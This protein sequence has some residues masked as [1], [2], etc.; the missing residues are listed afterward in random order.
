MH[1][2]L[3]LI[4]ILFLKYCFISSLHQVLA[5]AWGIFDLPCR[6]FTCSM[7]SL[8]RGVYP[9]RDWTQAP[10]LGARILIPGPLGE[11]PTWPILLKTIDVRAHRKHMLWNSKTCN[12]TGHRLRSQQQ[13]VETAVPSPIHSIQNEG[14]AQC[15]ADGNSSFPFQF[16]REAEILPGYHKSLLQEFEK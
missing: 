5:M 14:E 4:F 10:A 1:P 12:T 15:G 13:G 11:V 2:I 6:F 9:N 7:Q 16:L 3:V 8:S